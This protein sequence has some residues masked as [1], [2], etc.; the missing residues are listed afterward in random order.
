MDSSVMLSETLPGV[1]HGD[2]DGGDRTH[3]P[4]LRQTFRIN[5]QFA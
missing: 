3:R 4:T 2:A 5:P 1:V